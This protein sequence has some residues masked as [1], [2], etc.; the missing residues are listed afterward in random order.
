MSWTFYT[1]SGVAKTAEYIG[2]EFPVGTIVQTAGLTAPS[3]WKLCDGSA[4][5]RT[6][7]SDL[8]STISTTYGSGDGSTTFNVPDAS[9]KMIYALPLASRMSSGTL[10]AATGDLTGTYPSLTI[11]SGT[12]TADKIGTS[13][14]SQLGV[15]QTGTSRSVSV[16][17]TAEV[18]T[19]ATTPTAI[20]TSAEL[21]TSSNG[22]LL[23]TWAAELKTSNAASSATYGDVQINNAG[24]W[25]GVGNYPCINYSGSFLYQV[26]YGSYVASTTYR[27]VGGAA[28]IPF[29]SG[30]M[31]SSSG[32]SQFRVVYYSGNGLYTAYAQNVTAT[33]SYFT[34]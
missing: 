26:A 29:V 1:A 9:G 3:G 12:I 25:I 28:R 23:L 14:A 10:A 6:T 18:S 4:I 22:Y 7:Y 24:T 33:M 2:S 27:K 11:P 19:T 16:T 17:Q 30:V 13:L 20:G 15:S 34:F 21:T 31:E 8:Y 5:S 32:K